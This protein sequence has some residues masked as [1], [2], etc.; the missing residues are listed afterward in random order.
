[1]ECE[2]AG[3]N[4][5]MEVA[6]SWPFAKRVKTVQIQCGVQEFRF[7]NAK[8]DMPVRQPREDVR[9]G[10]W[11]CKSENFNLRIVNVS[12]VLEA[13]RVDEIM[14][15]VS[16]K[17][18]KK[19]FKNLALAHIP[20]LGCLYLLFPLSGTLF[21]QIGVWFT[22]SFHSSFC[23]IFT[24]IESHSL[25]LSIP[26]HLLWLLLQSVYRYLRWRDICFSLLVFC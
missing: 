15:T 21:L 9:V 17:E 26:L 13:L 12:L 11:T 10:N 16:V 24:P 23:L 6:R 7:G 20:T 3:T 2:R 8:F 18:L 1:M 14:K 25:A 4:E 19:C 22:F 5:R